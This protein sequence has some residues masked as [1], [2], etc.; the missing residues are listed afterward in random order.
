MAT[1]TSTMEPKG[2]AVDRSG[3]ES[4]LFEDDSLSTPT[5]PAVDTPVEVAA[6]QAVTAGELIDASAVVSAILAALP[7][8]T[9]RPPTATP[10]ALPPTSTPLPHR[11]P[12]NTPRPTNTPVPATPTPSNPGLLLTIDTGLKKISRFAASEDGRYLAA[13]DNTTVRIWDLA[14]GEQVRDLPVSGVIG[15]FFSPDGEQIATLTSEIAQLWQTADGTLLVDGSIASSSGATVAGGATL[16]GSGFVPVIRGAGRGSPGDSPGILTAPSVDPAG[17]LDFALEFTA[18]SPDYGN[19]AASINDVLR[20][21]DADPFIDS[22]GAA[23]NVSLYFNVDTLSTGETFKGGFF[24]DDKDQLNLFLA[25]AKLEGSG[26]GTDID[27]ALY[28]SYDLFMAS[29][30]QKVIIMLTDGKDSYNPEEVRLAAGAGFVVAV[31]GDIM[32]MPG[33]PRHPAALDIALD[34]NGLVVGLT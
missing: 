10:T 14:T 8:P 23:N 7:T 11:T 30:R 19:A 29:G 17:G 22:L 32:T 2:A 27:E 18:G 5:P 1:A 4:G 26:G 6:D 28:F 15:V 31:C 9:P 34:E 33:L 24:T 25:Q 3:S 21:T 16:G 20:L 13:Y 12:T